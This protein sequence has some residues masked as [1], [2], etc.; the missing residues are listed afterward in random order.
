MNDHRQ[1]VL[2]AFGIGEDD[3]AANRAGTLG[4]RQAAQLRKSGYMNL[5]AAFFAGAVLAAILAFIANKPLKPAQFITAGILFLCVLAVGINDVLKTGGAA[6]D[7]RVERLSGPITVSSRGK[8]GWFLVVGGRSFRVP[9][10]VWKIEN[11]AP[12][13][14]YF[15]PKANRVVSMEPMT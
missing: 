2:K 3:L 7:G 14:V 5:L 9:V 15:A 8:Q 10:H 13:H 1:D 4:A 11:G 12:Y 6:K